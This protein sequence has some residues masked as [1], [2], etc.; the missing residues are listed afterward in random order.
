MF[1]ASPQKTFTKGRFMTTT[2]SQTT[3]TS[4]TTPG[5]IDI[6]SSGDTRGVAIRQVGVSHVDMPINILEKSGS[7]QRVNADITMSVSLPAESKGT[8]MSR[9][10]KQLTAEHNKTS[11]SFD[12]RPFLQD[13]KTLL[14]ANDAHIEIGFRYFVDKKAPVTG[15]SAP[16]GFDCRFIADLRGDEYTFKLKLDVPAATLCPCSKAISKYGAHNQ[17]AEIRVCLDVDTAHEET[18]V[19]WIEELVREL[20]DCA[21]CPVYPILKREDEKYVTE[22]AYENPRFV[23][24][25]IREAVL[26]LRNKPC[27]KGFAVEAE[28]FESIHGHNAWAKH[29]EG[30]LA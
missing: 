16:M 17:R 30:S 20:E 9:F 14:E 2:S 7:V 1:S 5:L 24:D 6:Q 25:V 19:L 21:S 26:V 23:E 3:I 22:R 28:A 15:I 12:L 8:H 10:I 11:F 27:L 13:T 4:G 18:P 29:A